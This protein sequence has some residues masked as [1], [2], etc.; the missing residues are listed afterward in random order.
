MTSLCSYDEALARLLTGIAPL[1]AE[2]ISLDVTHRRVLSAPILAP[3]NRPV[4]SL[5]AMD[6]YAIR[7]EDLERMRD[8]LEVVGHAYPGALSCTMLK[9]GHAVRVTTGARLPVATGR[10]VLDE[11]VAIAGDRVRLVGKPCAKPHIRLAGS[12]FLRGDVLVPSGTV[13]APATIMAAAA[14]EASTVWVHRKP[15]VAILVTGD[16]IV[17]P[18]DCST[19]P[20]RTPDSVSHAVAAMVRAW[21]GEIVSRTACADDCNALADRMEDLPARCDVIVVIGGASGSERDHARAATRRCG[22]QPLFAGVAMKPGKPVWAARRTPETFVG[23]PGNP[24]AALVTARILLAPLVAALSGMGATTALNWRPPGAGDEFIGT[25][26]DVFVLAHRGP[27]GV[28]ANARRESSSHAGLQTANAL[29][30]RNGS[31]DAAV[32]DL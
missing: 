21:G 18:G 11:I 27:N 9:P 28:Q 19:R 17:A 7:D 1:E 30:R 2:A 26:S 24:I 22:G 32:L 14:A 31:N 23:L 8:G 25:C 20:D 12:D 4:F 3:R 29:V 15:R 10:V 13:M 16:E 6:G 5:A